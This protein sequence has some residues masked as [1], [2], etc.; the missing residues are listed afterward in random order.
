MS[1]E[2]G[3][4][5]VY[6]NPDELN[7][8]SFSTHIMRLFP[9]GSAPL[10]ALTGGTGSTRAKSIKHGYFSKT[11][12]FAKL[13]INDGA[14][15]AAGDETL[16][17]DST[18]GVVA[19]QVYHLT[20]TRENIRVTSVTSSTVVVVSRSF[21]RVAAAA[22]VDDDEFIHV[23]TAHEQGSARPTARSQT[24]VWRE[25]F[26]QIFRNAWAITDTARASYAEAGYSNIAENKRDNAMH[27]AQDMEAAMFFGQ[28][29]LDTV[30]T[31][32]NGKPISSTQ[33]VIDAMLEYAPSH[34]VAAAATTNYDELEDMLV[35]AF[36]FSTNMGNAK[37]RMAFTGSAGMKVI[38]QIGRAQTYDV[39]ISL[40]ENKFGMV[41]NSIRTYKGWVHV[42]EH[43]LFNGLGSDISSSLVVLDKP[44]IKLAYLDGRATRPE[45]YGL[46]GT[47]QQDA[48]AVAGDWNGGVDAQGGSVTSEMAVEFLNPFSGVVITGLTAGN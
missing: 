26:T 39:N 9:N 22:I 47:A 21:G 13:T 15:Y 48:G 14:G 20:R 28:A 1:F 3:M 36:E 5:T 37:E 19:G 23:G 4:F 32:G 30:N 2:K 17:V 42:V 7:Q 16:T 27:H 31:G 41:F 29:S 11:W 38:Q 10:F 18:A 6:M 35:P 40:A 25:N 45:T 34:V 24:T 44:A 33:G 46:G 12:T 43:P 8:K